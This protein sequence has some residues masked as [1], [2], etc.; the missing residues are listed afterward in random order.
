MPDD[1]LREAPIAEPEPVDLGGFLSPAV[2]R[3]AREHGVDPEAVEGTGRGGRVTL[4]DI[5]Q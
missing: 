2:R 5:A 1:L 3:F 4:R